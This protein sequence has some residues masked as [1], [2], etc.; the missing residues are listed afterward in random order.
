MTPDDFT[1]E[2][3]EEHLAWEAGL[4]A[5]QDEI[6]REAAD[7]ARRQRIVTEAQRLQSMATR[8]PVGSIGRTAAELLAEVPEEVDWFLPGLL[9]PKWV[10]KIA[11]REKL[12][13]GVFTAYLLGC[14]E[15]G[16]PTVFGPSKQA[17]ALIYTEEPEDAFREKV[18][19]AGLEQ[20]TVILGHELGAYRWDDKSAV[21]V[22][23]AV[24]HDHRVIF[25]DNLA[26]A[27]GVSGSE[28]N[29]NT[30]GRM[31]GELGDRAAA[32]GLCVILNHHHKKGGTRLGDKS[33]GGTA[34]A[35]ACDVNVEMEEVVENALDR[36]RR[37]TSIGRL[38]ATRWIRGIELSDDGHTYADVDVPESTTTRADQRAETRLMDLIFLRGFDRPVTAVQFQQG[39]PAYRDKAVATVKNHLNALVAAEMAVKDTLAREHTWS[40]IN[41]PSI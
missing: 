2:E 12:G 4:E 30:L 27:T 6:T 24:Y 33:R 8:P 23:N 40:A 28:E 5:E 13:K 38:K 9:A 26:R 31:V 21:L 11:A 35:A 16:E 34:L 36:R 37:L 29:D 41:Q 22:E 1:D 15:R 7:L 39:V 25:I 19:D 17:T 10:V 20:A 32:A 14:M 3:I 18:A